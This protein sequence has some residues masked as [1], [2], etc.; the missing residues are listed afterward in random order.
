MIFTFPFP[1]FFFAQN[2]MFA[3][4]LEEQERRVR[5]EGKKNLRFKDDQWGGGEEE[6][7]TE[8]ARRQNFSKNMV[9][10]DDVIGTFF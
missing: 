2:D 10:Y 6:E 3:K 5:L 8:V 1:L 7:Y 9:N 4:A